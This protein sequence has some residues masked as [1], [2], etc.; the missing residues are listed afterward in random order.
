[1]KKVICILLILSIVVFIAACDLSMDFAKSFNN[2][3]FT[4]IYRASNY[5]VLQHNDTG[6][7]YLWIYP[8]G[9][10]GGLTVMLNADGMPLTEWNP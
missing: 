10:I 2:E 8:N 3:H 6:V 1:M 7:C 4:V 9:S 5:V